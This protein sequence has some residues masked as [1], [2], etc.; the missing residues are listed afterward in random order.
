MDP[1]TGAVVLNMN[2]TWMFSPNLGLVY[3]I[4]LINTVHIRLQEFLGNNA[5]TANQANAPLHSKEY[6]YD[7]I[8]TSWALQ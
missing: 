8:E 3:V 5:C 2:A 7:D 1:E 6:F 4:I